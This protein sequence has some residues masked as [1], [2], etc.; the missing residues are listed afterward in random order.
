MNVFKFCNIVFLLLFMLFNVFALC[1]SDIPSPQDREME[2]GLKIDLSESNSSIKKD[3]IKTKEQQMID[4]RKYEKTL[5]K[6]DWDSIKKRSSCLQKEEKKQFERILDGLKEGDVFS[7]IL[8]MGESMWHKLIGN[9]CKDDNPLTIKAQNYMKMLDN[10]LI[11]K[12]RNEKNAK[13][14]IH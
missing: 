11:D 12:Y 2:H 14:E 8:G 3:T 7:G 4:L 6:E 9:K 5:G 10:I 1:N 13:N